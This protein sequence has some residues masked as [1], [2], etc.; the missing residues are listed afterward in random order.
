MGIRLRMPRGEAEGLPR[1]AS[2]G[3]SASSRPER[4]LDRRRH[5]PRG[6]QRRLRRSSGPKILG[7]ATNI[8]FEGVVSKQLP[9]GRDPGAGRS[10]AL[11]AAGPGPARRHALEHERRRPAQ[12][13]DFAALG[14][15]L[16]ARSSAS[17][18]LSSVF[19]WVQAY[20][21]AGVTQRTVYRL[22]ERGRR[23]ARPAAAALLRRPPARR[24]P[25]PRHQ[26]HRQHRPDAPAEPDPAH[27]VAA[28]DHRR[29]D[30]DAHDQPAAGRHLAARRA[31]SRSSSRCSSPSARRSSSPPSGSRPATLNGHVEEMH[32]GHTIVKVFGRQQEAID[33]VRRARTSELYQASYQ[34]PVHLRD[35]PAGDELR[36]A[37]STTWRSRS[38]AA[39]R[40]RTG[41][42]SLGDVAGVHPVLAP[43]H[44]CRSSRPPAS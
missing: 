11:R 25:E 19:S 22:R 35:H 13:I 24:H 38:S 15:I 27:H 4:L 41:T 2:G 31:R 23:E 42:M 8:I 5:G 21:M 6:R 33:D 37:T 17:T 20:I 16:A 29:A 28:D 36:R 14:R 26:R 18:S 39:C 9:A 44:A 32:T 40:S 3:C 7:N 34:G 30:H 43:V 12:G 10:P 1:L